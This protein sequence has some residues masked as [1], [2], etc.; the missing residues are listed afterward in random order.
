MWFQV[1]FL[2]LA[3]RADAACFDFSK[4]IVAPL[5]A[6]IAAP[7]EGDAEASG[8]TDEQVTWAQVRGPVKAPIEKVYDLLLDHDTTRSSKVDEMD[9]VISARPGYLSFHTVKF[10]IKPFPLIKIRWTE[11]WGYALEAGTPEKPEQIVIS[12]EKIEG[13]GYIE[14]LCGSVVLRKLGPA[15]TDVYLYEEAKATQRSTEDTLKGMRG[16]LQTLRR[17]GS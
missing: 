1:L 17:K 12:Y 7:A 3:A 9:V 13:T 4:K 5:K 11:H 15:S 2:L 10:L 14:H 6:P 8:K 16:T